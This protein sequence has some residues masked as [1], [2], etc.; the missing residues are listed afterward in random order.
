M[1]LVALEV[2]NLLLLPILW[3]CSG[4]FPLDWLLMFPAHGVEALS[5]V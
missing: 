2:F 3:L 1:L 5:R 4:I